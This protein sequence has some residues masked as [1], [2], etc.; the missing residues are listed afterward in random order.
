MNSVRLYA[1]VPASVLSVML[2]HDRVEI[3]FNSC[4]TRQTD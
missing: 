2:G 1:E 4:L 3:K